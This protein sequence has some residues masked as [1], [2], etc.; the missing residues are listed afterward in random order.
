M[1]IEK[2]YTPKKDDRCMILAKSEDIKTY[3]Q[4]AFLF[5]EAKNDF[6]KLKSENVEFVIANNKICGIQFKAPQPV[7]SDEYQI[8]S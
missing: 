1:H 2:D 8:F 4:I 6:P 5:R 3:K 7:T